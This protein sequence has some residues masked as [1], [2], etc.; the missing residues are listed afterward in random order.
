[1]KHKPKHIRTKAEG[2]MKDNGIKNQGG[3]S[4][5]TQMYGSGRS[6]SYSDFAETFYLMKISKK[7]FKDF[8]CPFKSFVIV[9]SP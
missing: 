6:K 4:Y 9:F 3:S 7:S 2:R 8:L 1:M 5:S